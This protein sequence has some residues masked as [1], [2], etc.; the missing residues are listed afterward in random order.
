M[1]RKRIKRKPSLEDKLRGKSYGHFYSGKTRFNNLV[2]RVSNLGLKVSVGSM[3]FIGDYNLNLTNFLNM[4]YNE[5]IG[6]LLAVTGGAYATYSCFHLVRNIRQ[7]RLAAS[8]QYDSTRNP[9]YLGWRI[10][11]AGISISS[12]SL[13]N[14]SLTAAAYFFTE[15]AARFEEK[16]LEA[17]YGESFRRYRERTPRW[18]PNYIQNPIVNAVERLRGYLTSRNPNRR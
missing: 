5:Q 9:M 8:S 14:L 12:P 7:N 13:R 4:S 2:Q 1:G 18:V 17:E 3:L 10:L 11:S 15:V 6:S 16:I